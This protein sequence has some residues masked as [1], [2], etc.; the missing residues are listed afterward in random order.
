MTAITATSTAPSI[1]TRTLL[2]LVTVAQPLWIAVSLTQAAT[3][4]GFDLTRHPLSALANGDLGWL[5]ITNFVLAGLLTIAGSFGFR[6]ALAGKPGATWVPRLTLTAGVGLIAAGL[7]VMDPGGGFPVGHDEL[8]TTMSWHSAGHM[9]A[10]TA[11]FAALSA[12]CF[13]LGR[14]YTRTGRRGHAVA[15]RVAGVAILLGNAWAM[16]GQA[17]ASLGLAVGVFSAMLWVAY[18]AARLR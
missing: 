7:L 9:I 10:G 13:V 17:G 4:E 11:T 15:S 12:T 3:R 5:Q 16:S 18:S 6:R 1:K 14:F 8:P 2:G